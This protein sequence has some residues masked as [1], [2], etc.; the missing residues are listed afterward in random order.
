MLELEA[1]ITPNSAP[2]AVNDGYTVH[3]ML[4]DLS[5]RIVHHGHVG[6]CAAQNP[7]NK[8]PISSTRPRECLIVLASRERITSAL[9]TTLSRVRFDRWPGIAKSE[10]SPRFGCKG[11][12]GSDGVFSCRA[13]VSPALTMEMSHGPDPQFDLS[14]Q[15][16]RRREAFWDAAFLRHHVNLGVAIVLRSEGKLSAIRRETRKRAIAGTARQPSRGPATIWN[17]VKFAG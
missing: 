6:R 4:A 15:R 2:V 9:L 3:S 11:P 12:A 13:R 17:R 14:P 5:R 8:R 10:L 1:R 16:C 7:A